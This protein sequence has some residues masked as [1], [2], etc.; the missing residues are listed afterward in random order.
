[1]LGLLAASA[2]AAPL[3]ALG[4]TLLPPQGTL[5]RNPTPTFSWGA[6]GQT[7]RRRY[8]NL[9]QHFLFEYYPWYH[10][11]PWRHWDQWDRRPPLDIAATSIPALGPYSS[12]DARVLERH[13]RWIADTGIGAINVSWWG[14][15]RF[16]DRAVPLLM[17]V[18]RDHGLKVTFHLEPY[19]DTRVR[20]YADDILYLVREYGDKRAWDAMLVLPDAD[21]RE[22]PVFKS[23][24]TILP[25]EVTDC[26]GRTR[27]VPLWAP[28]SAWRQQTDT[29]R[30]ALRR[31]FDR[32]LLLADSSALDRVRASGFDGMAL[33][34][35]YVRPATW[36]ALARA[37]TEFDLAFSFNINAGF[38]GIE[39]RTFDPDGCY[40]PLLFEPPAQVDWRSLR[41]RE[42]A[43][44]TAMA[45][46]SESA[47]TTVGLQVDPGLANVRTG[48]FL[49]FVNSF[50]EWHEGTAF[51]PMKDYR[52]LTPAE[53]DAYHNALDG[54]YR[55]TVLTELLRPLLG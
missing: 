9:G 34:D 47:Q 2:A 50:N 4:A 45:R 53:R 51:E 23:F 8:A 14:R 36:P 30:D 48:E 13:A 39:P 24:A 28:V 37:C 6:A 7:L 17:D 46:I 38:D 19:T 25:F 49:V 27:Q 12:L 1:M 40:S 5:R 22:G 3:S 42:R 55:L 21:G 52:S 41:G 18:M 16:E 43:R 10:T 31:D 29:V 54:D 20:S 32:V 15:D 35:N 26:K 44:L 11:D 33:Y